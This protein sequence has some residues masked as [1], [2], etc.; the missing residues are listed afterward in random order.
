MLTDLGVRIGPMVLRIAGRTAL[1][2]LLVVCGAMA[3][4]Y[5]FTVVIMA[6]AAHYTP[7]NTLIIALVVGVPMCWYL[8]QQHFTLRALKDDLSHARDAA[9]AAN[10][11]KSAFLATMSHEIRTPLNGVLGMAQAMAA[12]DLGVVQRER[13]DVI[14]QSGETLLAIL[15]DVLDLSKIEAGKLEL[16]DTEFDLAELARGAHAAFTAIAHKKGLS[17]DLIVEPSATGVWRG[18]P[19]RVRQILYNLISNALKFTDVGEIRVTA[20]RADE[21]LELV[22]RDTGIGMSPE[23]VAG[24][25]AKFAQADTSTTRRF[26]GTGLGLSICRE[27]AALM[28]GTIAVVSAPGAGSTLTVRLDLPWLRASSA[29]STHSAAPAGPAAAPAISALRVLAAEDNQINQLVL[30]TLLH[31]AGISPVVVEDGQACIVAW[32]A[33]TWD[34]ILMDVQMP[35]MDGPAAARAIRAREAETGRARTPIVA[36]TANAMA[37]QVLAYFAAGMDGH[38]SKPIEAAK[39]FA[40][41]DAALEAEPSGD[42]AVA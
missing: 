30:K 15:N 23:T 16:E 9:D 11:A 22:V 27:L 28:G 39:L 1:L 3:A 17:F 26:G 4:D 34:V 13:L 6:D 19:T 2:V 29:Q 37:H 21:R 33:Q 38:V 7:L 24:L 35:V 12:D 20:R 8:T 25:F 42:T 31:Q 40:A 32:E 14:R 10:E 18:D 41:I 5:L 36:L